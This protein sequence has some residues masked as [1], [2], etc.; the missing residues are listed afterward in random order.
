MINTNAELKQFESNKLQLATFTYNSVVN[1]NLPIVTNYLTKNHQVD[2]CF[3]GTLALNNLDKNGQIIIIDTNDNGY[4]IY[5]NYGNYQYQ[6]AIKHLVR[7]SFQNKDTIRQWSKRMLCSYYQWL[8]KKRHEQSKMDINAINHLLENEDNLMFYSKS[9]IN[10]LIMQLATVDGTTLDILYLHYELDYLIKGI[11]LNYSNYQQINLSV[12]NALIESTKIQICELNSTNFAT[13]KTGIKRMFIQ[14][15]A[16]TLSNVAKMPRVIIDTN[17]NI[18]ISYLIELCQKFG[19]IDSA[20]RLS[21][22]PF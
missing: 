8:C 22:F 16:D 14:L 10:W 2:G 9:Y 12:I 15:L 3:D 13:N 4:G 5:D 17:I 18:D 19:L 6:Y 21:T 20:K 7:A 11:I 1:N